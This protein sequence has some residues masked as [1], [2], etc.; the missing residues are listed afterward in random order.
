MLA[1]ILKGIGSIRISLFC[2]GYCIMKFKS[3][4]LGAKIYNTEMHTKHSLNK[5]FLIGNTQG[6][7]GVLFS[8]CNNV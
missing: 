3:I 1:L 4:T 5:Y 8:L 6:N 7:N 2:D